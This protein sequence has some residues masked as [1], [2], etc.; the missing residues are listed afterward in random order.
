MAQKKLTLD[1]AGLQDFIDNQIAPFQDSLDKIANTDTDSGV[2]INTLT[3]NGVLSDKDPQIFKTQ[4]PL[5]IGLLATDSASGGDK[6]VEKVNGV[7]ESI[8]NVYTLQT[9]LFRDL[10]T[11]LNTTIKK[12][13]DG[14]HDNLVKID[15]K[16]FLDSLGTVPGDFQ[17]SGSGSG[18]QT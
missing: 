18:N 10:H 9:K 1:K 5:S 14:Q 11:N 15:G 3:G 12:L 4:H 13:M 7:C 16:I 8:T 2:S 17:G 6:L